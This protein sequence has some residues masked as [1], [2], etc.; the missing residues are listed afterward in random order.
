MYA[1]RTRQVPLVTSASTVQLLAP[2]LKLRAWERF[3]LMCRGLTDS[4][5]NKLVEDTVP[6]HT[7]HAIEHHHQFAEESVHAVYRME[8]IN[9]LANP[10]TTGIFA[11]RTTTAISLQCA[12]T[13]RRCHM[14]WFTWIVRRPTPQPTRLCRRCDTVT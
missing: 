3:R 4:F 6:T 5:V 14:K 13:G 8:F 9:A 11:I 7:L 2:A 1:A 10:A 12:P